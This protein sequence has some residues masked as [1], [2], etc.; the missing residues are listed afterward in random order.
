MALRVVGG[1]VIATLLGRRDLF[2]PSLDEIGF[3]FLTHSGSMVV[4]RFA[5]PLLAVGSALYA[6]QGVDFVFPPS[7]VW[8]FVWFVHV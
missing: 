6:F 8:L 5:A 3:F 4:G 2:L 7:V 1:Q